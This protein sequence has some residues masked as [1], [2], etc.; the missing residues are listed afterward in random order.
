MEAQELGWAHA[1]K[2]LGFGV[3]DWRF[4]CCR[5]HVLVLRF[6]GLGLKGHRRST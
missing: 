6:K 5:V 4:D 2:D 3:L 1:V